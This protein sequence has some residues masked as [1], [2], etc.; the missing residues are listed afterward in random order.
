MN[1]VSC[2]TY[3]VIN[4]VDIE[5]EKKEIMHILLEHIAA[6]D[7]KD[8]DNTVKMYAKDVIIHISNESPIQGKNHRIEVIKRTFTNLGNTKSTTKNDDLYTEISS[9]GDMAWS[10]GQYTSDYV[11]DGNS[12]IA[13]GKYI[14]IWK[15]VDDEW[16]IAAFS[17][18][19]IQPNT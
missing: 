5:A 2:E 1:V 6:Y 16:K 14:F 15:K 9:T 4:V 8:L 19:S 10:C 13:K 12:N 18:S 7:N 11:T 3:I 17:N